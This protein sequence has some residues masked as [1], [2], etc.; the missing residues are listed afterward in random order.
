MINIL[1]KL[2]SIGVLSIN[3]RN[4]NFILKYNPRKY[5][6]LVDNKKISKQLALKVGIAVPELYGVIEVQGQRKNLKHILDQ[7]NDFVIK[8]AQGSGGDGIIVI[9]R[10]SKDKY[11]Q[12]SGE[13]MSYDEIDYH[14]SKIISG[15]YSLG[16]L[17]DEVLIEYRVKFDPIFDSISYRGIPDIRII[18]L[19][20]VPVMS[21]ARLPTRMSGGKANL[22][23]GAIGVGID[24]AKGVTQFAVLNNEIISE[25]PD[26]GNEVTGISIPN[27]ETILTI[28][29]KCYDLTLLGYQGVDIVLDKD[30]GPMILELNARP[31]LNIQIANQLGLLPRLKQVE[32]DYK[33]LKSC[34]ERVNYTLSRWKN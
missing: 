12:V 22:H 29:S 11:Y 17:P 5:Y 9:D 6:P 21:M 28:A 19:F 24:I 4:A 20:G 10:K 3:N 23:Q 25:H 31:G 32:N 7:H 33:N 2:K 15:M 8:P 13:L 27:W 16:G 14:V 18:T 1:K 26:T 34:E 30:K